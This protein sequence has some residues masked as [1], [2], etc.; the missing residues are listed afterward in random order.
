M[1]ITNTLQQGKKPVHPR[2]CLERTRPKVCQLLHGLRVGGAEV[3]AARLARQ[4]R[5]HFR[6]SFVC[7]DELGTLGEE[8]RRDGYPVAVLERRPGVDWGCLFRLARFLQRERINLVHA[9]QY[10][11]FFYGAAARLLYR[12]PPVLFTEHGRFHPDYP[13]RK[14]ILANR[15]LLQRRDRVVGVGRAVGQAVIQNEGIS[16][17]RVQII[18]NGI[19]MSAFSSQSVDRLAIR[20]EIGVN[21][22]D[23]VIILVARLDPLKDHATAIRAMEHVV[24]HR[25]EARLVLVGEG[26]ELARI[27]NMVHER[28]LKP[29]VRFLGLRTDVA[30]LLLAA[31]VFLLTSISEGIPLTVIEAMAAGLPVV[32]TQVGGVSEIVEDGYTGLLA[33]AGDDANLAERLLRLAADP[34]LRAQMGQLGRQRVMD[35]FSESQMHDRY[36]ELYQ[37]MLHG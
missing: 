30:R 2:F 5:D 13:R 36:L 3:L 31:D 16:A 1:V 28:T 23:F 22:W 29:Y 6:F 26:A 12:R 32:A 33:P 7:L 10:T 17:E 24:W 27:E 25:R 37:E 19:D 14:R 21:A 20:R 11:P 34:A 18:Y 35:L 4:L 9:H 15:L 8:L